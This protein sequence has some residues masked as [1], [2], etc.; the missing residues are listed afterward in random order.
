MNAGWTLARRPHIERPS[1]ATRRPERKTGPER[2]RSGP[3]QIQYSDCNQRTTNC[4]AAAAK[5]S[6]IGLTERWNEAVKASDQR[7]IS[8]R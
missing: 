4:S 2:R 6:L 3:V 8:G 7:V 5:R 1:L